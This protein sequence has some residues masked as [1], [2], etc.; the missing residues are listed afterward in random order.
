MGTSKGPAIV[1]SHVHFM[2]T[3]LAEAIRKF[4]DEHIGDGLA[5]PPDVETVLDMHHASGVAAV[6]NLPYAH[7]PGMADD[8]NA[9]MAEVSN[10]YADHPVEV[11]NGCTVHPDDPAP[12]DTVRRASVEFGARVLKLHC[13]VGNYDA[14][15]PR[16]DPV[17]REA[18]QAAM[19]VV[20]HVGHD[21]SGHTHDHE[22][23]SIA[24]AASRHPGTTLIVA[25]CGHYGHAET[26]A[27]M[28]KHQNLWADLTPV[29][30]ERPALS[31]AD[32]ESVADR[33]LLGTDAPNVAL[34][35]ESQLEWLDGL[36]LSEATLNAVQG[37][38]ADRL[39]P[40]QKA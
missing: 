5:Y 1:D 11:L 4:F 3:R 38:N 35:L 39:V 12:G 32:I 30:F 8:L 27:L 26:L 21:V 31:G 22:L 6:W 33:I 28:A 40:R 36:G 19:P 29:V 10:D 25:H 24:T 20:V 23:S 9:A 16:L 7:K 13:S 34:T 18:G 15:D 2:P 14:D 37:A 17:Y